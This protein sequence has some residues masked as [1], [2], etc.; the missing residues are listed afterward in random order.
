MSLT[1]SSLNDIQSTLPPPPTPN[2]TSPPNNP[3]PPPHFV[4]IE[5]WLLN[6][7][8]NNDVYK[9][10]VHHL[11]CAFSSLDTLQVSYRKWGYFLHFVFFFNKAYRVELL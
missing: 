7:F 8:G 11:H 4:N 10:M 6:K 5:V 1:S 3:P 9:Q 2:N